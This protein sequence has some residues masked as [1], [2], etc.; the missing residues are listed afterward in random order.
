MKN[1]TH[2][3]THTP[4]THAH[5]HEREE[6]RERERER[7]QRTKHHPTH[8]HIT[9]HSFVSFPLLHSFT[10]LLHSLL[11]MANF[12]THL[13]LQRFQV[14]DMAHVV[15]VVAAVAASAVVFHFCFFPSFPYFIILSYLF[16]LFYFIFCSRERYVCMQGVRVYFFLQAFLCC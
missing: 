2:T 6:E 11:Q 12:S 4:F 16:I 7:R 9:T 8:A 10:E 5:R 14:M 13:F 15:A 1:D 3:H